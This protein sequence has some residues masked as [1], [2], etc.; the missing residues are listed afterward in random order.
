[1]QF[2]IFSL[3]AVLIGLALAVGCLHRAPELPRRTIPN[4]VQDL[5]Q[6]A[7]QGDAPAMVRLADRYQ[8]GEGVRQDFAK[9]MALYKR[10]ALEGNLPA[11]V[12]LGIMYQNGNGA[13]RDYK[14][15]YEWFLRAAQ[16]GSPE[17]QWQ[18]GR[19]H[20]DGQGVDPSINQA[21]RW[22]RKA[23]NQG[24]HKANFAVLHGYPWYEDGD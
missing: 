21:M 1:M 2:R 13:P 24:H 7:D 14:K 19:C 18:V 9:A 23:A 8:A 10:A 6:K 5:E 20:Y 12:K 4:Q 17:A 16:K 3:S 15:A 22:W 11:H